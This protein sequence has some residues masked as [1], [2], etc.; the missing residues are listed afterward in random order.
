MEKVTE[1]IKALLDKL[2][3]KEKKR[4]R[5]AMLYFGLPLLA[6]VALTIW[7]VWQAQTL[8]IRTQDLQLLE[9]KIDDKQRELDFL[10]TQ[11]QRTKDAGDHVSMG[12]WFARKGKYSDAIAAYDR[13]IEL[14]SLPFVLDLKG[15][16]LLRKGESEKAVK[17]E[18]RCIEIDPTYIWCHYNLALAYWARGETSKAV[19]EVKK[20]I[21]LDP[22]FRDII[23]NDVQFK[24]FEVSPEFKSLI[25]Q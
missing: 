21:G 11:L 15:Y 22:S 16:S 8:K 4:R 3:V 19:E 5:N 20:V 25:Q 6:G 2:E 17:T 1:D 18:K 24:K 23:G 10:R 7:T 14:D 12:I 9:H 13:A